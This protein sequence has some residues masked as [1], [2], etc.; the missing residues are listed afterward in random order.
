MPELGLKR[1]PQQQTVQNQFSARS[2]QA[3]Y[4]ADRRHRE[5]VESRHEIPRSPGGVSWLSWARMPGLTRSGHR[6]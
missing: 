5:I 2:R 1:M 4:E 3:T 6:L